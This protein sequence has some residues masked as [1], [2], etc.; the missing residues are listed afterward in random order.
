[1]FVIFCLVAPAVEQEEREAG[2]QRLYACHPQLPPNP[3]GRR[4]HRLGNAP[5]VVYLA[6]CFNVISLKW[7]QGCSI[8]HL[9]GNH[10]RFVMLPEQT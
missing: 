10:Q 4:T 2:C 5:G 8:F 9:K 6:F 1:M 3:A 7:E